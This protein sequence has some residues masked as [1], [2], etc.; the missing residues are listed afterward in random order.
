MMRR[1]SLLCLLA[2]L[3]TAPAHAAPASAP[4]D[5]YKW[6]TLTLVTSTGPGGT[7]DLIARLVARHMPK[8]LPGNPTIIIQNMPGA[9]NVLATNF[10]Y[11]NAPKDGTTIGVINDAIPLHQVIDGRG[12]RY[13]ADKFNWLGSPGDRNSVTFVWHTA[14]VKTIE[15]IKTKEIVLGGTGVASSIVMFPTAMNKVLGT[16][17]KIVMGYRSSAEVFLAMERG[18]VQARSVG[19]TSVLSEYPE[20]ISEKKIVFVV[21]MGA[22]RDPLLPDVPL[23]TELAK[24]DEERQILRLISS[25]VLLG[26]P[27]LAPPGVPAD[28]VAA[29]RQAFGA[30]MKDKAFL[31]DAEKISYSVNALSG[32]DIARIVHE[33]MT[34]TPAVIAKAKAVIASA[35][36]GP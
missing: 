31:A 9:G 22:K 25:P 6:K 18:E 33:T 36:G 1:R 17:F 5:G 7:Y 10:L 3:L 26:Q 12:V 29:L 32:D 35:G 13:D 20:W 4:A 16:K 24:T 27:Y 8:Y 34:A 23:V 11:T 14:G 21:Q 30:T 19:L 28:R 15:D 2:A